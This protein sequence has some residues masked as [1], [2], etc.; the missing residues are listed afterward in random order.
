MFSAKEQEIVTYLVFSCRSSFR[1]LFDG[2]VTCIVAK[3][4]HVRPKF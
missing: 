4:T 2:G 3:V 1:N